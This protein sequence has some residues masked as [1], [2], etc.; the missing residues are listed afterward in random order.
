MDKVERVEEE[1]RTLNTRFRIAAEAAGIGVWDWDLET[2]ALLWDEQMYETYD[3]QEEDFSG[4]YEAWESVVVPEDLGKCRAILEEV[5]LT[6]SP[7]DM[8]FR[9]RTRNGTLRHIAAYGRI[10]P[11]G[12]DSRRR[13]IG[14]NYDITQRKTA[15]MSLQQSE[16]RLHATLNSI[17]DGV[18]AT[19]REGRVR[20]MNPVAELHT[21]WDL[22]EAIGR[23]VEQVFRSLDEVS[24]EELPLPRVD[25]L[26]GEEVV[27]SRR[28]LVSRNGAERFIEMSVAYIRTEDEEIHGRTFVWRDESETHRMERE[29]RMLNQSLERR[30]IEQ[31]SKLRSSEQFLRAILDSLSVAIV[32]LD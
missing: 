21:G 16:S 3:I 8:T 10:L 1:L 19:D 28:V 4:T 17:T 12:S 11:E 25:A 7:L 22:V 20:R 14:V 13:M 18:I 2:G 5:K 32:A 27:E 6:G 26:A 29:L 24:R 23:P 30:V 15:E 31:T 9:I